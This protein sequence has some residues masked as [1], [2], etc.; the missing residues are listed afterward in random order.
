MAIGALMMLAVIL[1]LAF[2]KGTSEILLSIIAFLG[3]S[4]VVIGAGMALGWRISKASFGAKEAQI[5]FD[6]HQYYEE[7]AAIADLTTKKVLDEEVE[8]DRRNYAADKNVPGRNAGAFDILR[9]RLHFRSFPI[10]HRMAPMYLLDKNFRVVDWNLAFSL[11][12]EHTM[13]G[14]RGVSVLEWTYYLDNYEEVL[15]HGV[16]AFS[17]PENFPDVDVE[18]IRYMN[19]RYGVVEAVK[20][21]YKIRDDNGID[22]LGWLII[23]ELSFPE[24]PKRLQFNEDLIR[25]LGVDDLWTEYAASYDRLLPRTS[26]YNELLDE[27]LGATGGLDEIADGARVLDLGAGTGNISYRLASEAK[28]RMIIAVDNNTAMLEILKAKCT[29]HLR[30]DDEH[31]G[32]IPIKQDITTLFGIQEQS[33]DYAI[34]NNV[35]YSV[36]D[37]VSCLKETFNVLRPGGEIRISGP[38]KDTDLDALFDRI[39]SDLKAVG[40]YDKLKRDFDHVL[41]INNL[42]LTPFLHRWDMNDLEKMLEDAGFS[43]ITYRSED[44]YAGQAQI[45]GARK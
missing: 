45:I 14:R 21:A 28:G 2:V 25:L 6:D 4:A 32:V 7:S 8:E 13:E 39:K 26:V 43:E 3:V 1:L 15:D 27:M 16:A 33:F 22:I 20:R 30:E 42:R 18:N 35:L 37:P 9:D 44:V 40:L 36:S 24:I 12:F 41:A 34:L 5:T 19:D 11:A 23:M 31:A 38:K 17:D 29:A 10:G